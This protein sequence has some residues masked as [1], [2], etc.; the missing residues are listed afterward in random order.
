[1]TPDNPAIIIG[2]EYFKRSFH[3]VKSKYL[4]FIF[5][6]S[7]KRNNNVIILAIKFERKTYPIPNLLL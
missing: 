5:L 3:N 4:T 2:T 7:F 6:N 1:M